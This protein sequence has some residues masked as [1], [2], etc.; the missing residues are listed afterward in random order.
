MQST[1]KLKIGAAVLLVA[2]GLYAGITWLAHRSDNVAPVQTAAASADAD[3]AVTITEQQAKHVTVVPASLHTFNTQ[4]DAVGNID[5]NQDRVTQV[6]S[7]YQGSVKQV[8]A[9]AGDDVAKGQPLFT[10][11]SPDLVQAESNLISTA[12]LLELANKTLDRARKMLE[13]QA[14]AQ[15]D[16]EQATSDQQSAAGNYQAARNALRIFGKSDAEMDRIAASRKID[17]EMTVVSPFTGRIT[18]R[19]VAPGVLVQPGTAPAPFTVADLSSVWMVANVAEDQAVAL[20][21]GQTVSISVDALPGR[22]LQGSI[23]Y[24][25][26]AVD[27][28]T[29]RVS[30]RSEIRD[31]HHELLPQM[32]ASFEVQTGA[33]I[34]S[35]AVPPNAIVREGDGTMTVF[36]TRD[37]R[38]F[39]R[40]P[41]KLGMQQDGLDQILEGLPANEHV[42]GDGALFISNALALQSQ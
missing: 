20:R 25:G 18:A 26:S 15:K 28:N 16:I 11:D 31:P 37:G 14:N 23:S 38:H 5:F 7:N 30:V 3:D 17:G 21:I 42:A 9:K 8:L 35:V 6:F 39:V 36:S 10:V 40:R 19:S 33:S 29:H 22:H 41:V 24:I 4:L 2:V 12:G 32:L 13:V 1:G 34:A 27:P